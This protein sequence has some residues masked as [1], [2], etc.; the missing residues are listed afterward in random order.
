MTDILSDRDILI[1]AAV[2]NIDDP[3][4]LMAL[5]DEIRERGDDDLAD[6]IL[7]T[8]GAWQSVLVAESSFTND[9]QDIN[10][11]VN[12]IKAGFKYQHISRLAGVAAC[13]RPCV[14]DQLTDDRYKHIVH[15]V[16]LYAFRLLGSRDFSARRNLVWP[17]NLIGPVCAVRE[18]SR[19]AGY[20]LFNVLIS[21]RLNHPDWPDRNEEI[22]YHRAVCR[23][24]ADYPSFDHWKEIRVAYCP[25]MQ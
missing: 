19:L 21:A 13:R 6:H 11:L 4:P 3:V 20:S 24:L 22:E 7:Y 14:W 5:S 10:S 16:W 9:N 18:L 25:N 12:Q 8:S 1:K 17:N 23:V 15:S 2:A